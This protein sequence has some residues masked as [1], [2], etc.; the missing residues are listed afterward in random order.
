MYNQNTLAT[1]GKQDTE[2]RQTNEKSKR[3]TTNRQ[4]KNQNETQHRKKKMSKSDPTK[5]QERHQ[6]NGKQFLLLIRQPPC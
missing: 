6:A 4:T 1:L 2:R 5:H 3:N